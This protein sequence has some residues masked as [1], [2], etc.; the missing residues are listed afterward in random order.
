MSSESRM[1]KKK[2]SSLVDSDF[3]REWK[4]SLYRGGTWDSEDLSPLSKASQ[5]SEAEPSWDRVVGALWG[6]PLVATWT[7]R[8]GWCH[9]AGRAEHRLPG[10]QVTVTDSCFRHSP[11]PS[12]SQHDS[13][14]PFWYHSWWVSLLLLLPSLLRA[15]RSWLWRKS[16]L[17][18]D[19]CSGSEKY[20]EGEVA[21]LEVQ[22]QNL[23]CVTRSHMPPSWNQSN[24]FGYLLLF[25]DLVVPNLLLYYICIVSCSIK[26][27]VHYSSF[28]KG[29]YAKLDI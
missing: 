27:P 9:S 26:N 17:T 5:Q 2:K 11:F 7:L 25:Y 16:L 20:Q 22:V 15:L 1:Q 14:W 12:L 23:S 21:H 10:M 28:D 24:I 3:Q 4:N 13:A 8:T 19:T 18:P 29:N 6:R